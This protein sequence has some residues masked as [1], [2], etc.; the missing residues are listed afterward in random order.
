MVRPAVPDPPEITAFLWD[1]FGCGWGGEP[2]GTGWDVGANAGQSVVYMRLLFKKVI[3]FEP[4]LG[5]Y[6]L[7]RTLFPHN[8]IHRVALTDHDGEVDLALPPGE[9]TETGQLVTPGTPGME[10]SVRDW[11]VVPRVT[12][13]GRTADSL[14]RVLGLPDF[15]KVDTEGHEAR[16]LS[17]A[18][19]ILET[20]QTD[21]LIE[22]HSE[23]NYYWCMGELEDAGYR[24]EVQRHPHYKERS[25]KWKGHGWLRAF[26]R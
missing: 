19:E 16:V 14:A 1:G 9:Q 17:G 22:F 6:D 25:P 20:R 26:A 7:F 8:D 10:W 15:I 23:A 3:S 21:W 12:V 4:Y 11:S 13:P 2:A 5:S 24:V 18:Q